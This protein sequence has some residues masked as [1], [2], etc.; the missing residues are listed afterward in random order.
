MRGQLNYCFSADAW[1]IGILL[2]I[3]LTGKHPFNADSVEKLADRVLYEQISFATEEWEC[4]S[5]SSKKLVRGLLAKNPLHR[6]N[7]KEVM[8]SKWMSKY[9]NLKTRPHLLSKNV[10]SNLQTKQ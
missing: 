10:P 3:M 2:V 1:A 4:V 5:D 9:A 7:I 8:N 6:I